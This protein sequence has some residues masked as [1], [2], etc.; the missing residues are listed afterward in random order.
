MFQTQTQDSTCKLILTPNRSLAQLLIHH[1]TPFPTA[2]HPILDS[3]TDSITSHP[4]QHRIP[5]PTASYPILDSN[6]RIPFPTSHPISDST[7]SHSRHPIPDSHSYLSR[8]P[9]LSLLQ[10][11]NDHLREPSQLCCQQPASL[12]TRP[13]HAE[14]FAL[15]GSV[16]K[17]F[18]RPSILVALEQ[19]LLKH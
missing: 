16:C 7:A 8:Y 1:S 9:P 3:I 4:R 6:A 14:A 18:W 19:R 5:L 10:A 12:L 13:G 17:C 2:P 11:C 15:Q